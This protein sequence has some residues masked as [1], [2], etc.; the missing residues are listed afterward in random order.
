MIQTIQPRSLAHIQEII[1]DVPCSSANA[2][3]FLNQIQ[4]R[5]TRRK[6]NET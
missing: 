1:L 2:E 5:K 3:N 4:T 6:R